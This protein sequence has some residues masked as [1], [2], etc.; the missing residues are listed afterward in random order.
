MNLSFSHPSHQLKP[1]TGQLV[2]SIE[3]CFSKAFEGRERNIQR[4]MERKT[5]TLGG[6]I[7]MRGMSW[8]DDVLSYTFR[9]IP[10]PGQATRPLIFHPVTPIN[11]TARHRLSPLWRWPHLRLWY[12]TTPPP[13]TLISAAISDIVTGNPLNTRGRVV[14]PWWRVHG[15]GFRTPFSTILH[16]RSSNVDYRT[17]SDR[18]R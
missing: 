15:N 8:R 4:E 2:F 9:T 7:S 16:R 1:S 3:K 12:V 18:I 13:F 11:L 10:G 14:C 17:S 5:Y 6:G